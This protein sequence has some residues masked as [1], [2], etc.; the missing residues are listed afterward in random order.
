[1][2][3]EYLFKEGDV[4]Q[5]AY[6]IQAGTLEVSKHVSGTDRVLG[7]VGENEILG[8]MSLIKGNKIHSASAKAL[9]EVHYIEVRSDVIN[10]KFDMGD[11]MMKKIVYCLVNRLQNANNKMIENL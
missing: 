6:L 4:S 10:E 8:E 7:T 9:D 1:M 5:A 11:P 3:G 2:P